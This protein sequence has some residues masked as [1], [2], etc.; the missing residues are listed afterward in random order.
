[1]IEVLVIITC[2]L[3]LVVTIIFLLNKFFKRMN[4]NYKN[5]FELSEDIMN[6]IKSNPNLQEKLED[7]KIIKN[8][9]KV[10][11]EII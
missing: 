2:M 4:N 3:T 11:I 8:T 5:F 1:M 9:I 10:K 7:K 6:K